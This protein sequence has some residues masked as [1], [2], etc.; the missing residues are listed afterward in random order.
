M[1]TLVLIINW[2]H[3]CKLHSPYYYWL[4][5]FFMTYFV[6]GIYTRL[7]VWGG[8]ISLDLNREKCVRMLVQLTC[9][10]NWFQMGQ[11]VLISMQN[12]KSPFLYNSWTLT[13]IKNTSVFW[14]D[15]KERKSR[16]FFLLFSY[17]ILWWL[18]RK[19]AT[20][21][22]QFCSLHFISAKKLQEMVKRCFAAW[23]CVNSHLWP[24]YYPVILN[25]NAPKKAFWK[26]HS[27]NLI[28]LK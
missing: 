11:I 27:Q 28:R 8:I 20:F 17:K 12:W 9:E 1:L 15:K 26:F 21:W 25:S 10:Q 2:P 18:Q 14:N 7:P 23:W 16:W 19:F 24:R 4:L 3:I 22:D 6:V 5:L 13:V